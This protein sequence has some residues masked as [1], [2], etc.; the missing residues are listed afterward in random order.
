MQPGQDGVMAIE[1]GNPPVVTKKG[2]GGTTGLLY[3]GRVEKSSPQVELLGT[4]DE[5]QAALGLARAE[6]EDEALRDIL[7]HVEHDLYVLMAEAG[8]ASENRGK[9]MP[10]RSAAST[11]MVAYLEDQ[12]QQVLANVQI[13]HE[14]VLPG[15]NRLEAAL[16]FARTVVRRAER[17]AVAAGFQGTLLGVFLNRLSDLCFLLARSAEEEHQV[18]R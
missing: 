14:F 18:S 12:V 11:E 17:R 3:G 2:D 9:L 5:V 6:A 16:D 8:T 7:A 4:L 10:G 1:E 15:S 13:P